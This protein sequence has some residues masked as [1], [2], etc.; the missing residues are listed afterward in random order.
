A[1]GDELARLI[2][3]DGGLDWLV[4]TPDGLF[5][6]SPGGRDQVSYRVGGG[7]NIVPVD[8]FF[9]DF[10][11]PGLLA[12][13]WRGDRVQAE[14]KLGQQLPPSIKILSPKQSGVIEAAEVTIEAEVTE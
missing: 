12:T 10:Y 4:C 7:L 8:R 14:G 1:T 13:L 3:L 2:T 11:R 6:G 9:K 5:D